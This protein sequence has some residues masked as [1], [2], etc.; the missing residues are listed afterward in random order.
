MA[1][2]PNRVS[3][4]GNACTEGFGGMSNSLFSFKILYLFVLFVA[5]TPGILLTIP[6]GGSKITVAVVH[7]LVFVVVWTLTSRPVLRAL[8]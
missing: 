8:H 3:G 6:T 7:A 2:Q 1:G 4:F 5:L